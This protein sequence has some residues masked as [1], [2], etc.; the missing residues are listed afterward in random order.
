MLDELFD[1]TPV[2]FRGLVRRS[3]FKAIE[4]QGF[5]HITEDSIYQVVQKIIPKKFLASTLEL[6]DHHRS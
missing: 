1:A 6:L 3:I 4:D 5:Q 2:F